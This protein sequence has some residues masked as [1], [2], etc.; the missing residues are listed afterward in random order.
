[1]A[2]GPRYRVPFRRRRE[3][4]TNYRSRRALVL[5]RVPRLVVRLSLKHTRI[6]IIEAEAIGDKVV[7]ST[8]S[9]ELAKKYGWLSNCGN[10]PSAYLSGL[11]CGYKALANGVEKAF[12]DVG[13]HIPSKG[14]RIFAALKGVVDA[15]VEV[16]HSEDIIPTE[17]VIN[18]SKI[19]DYATQLSSDS[20][21][22]KQKFS[23]ILTKGVRPE[24]LPEH[25]TMVKEKITSAFEKNL[26]GKKEET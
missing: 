1:M 4:K 21:V 25:F 19:A 16:P 18:G 5:S 8:H 6:Q 11:L 14:T 24:D 22:Y 12:L 9:R 2:T 10:V 3:G 7:V 23:K 13:L 15:G 26:K 17:N 20:E